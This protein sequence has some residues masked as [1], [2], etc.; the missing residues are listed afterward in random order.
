VPAAKLVWQVTV[1]LWAVELTG[2]LE[3]PPIAPAP[4]LKVIEPD[5]DAL[6]ELEVTVATTV[7]VWLVTGTEGATSV[8]ALVVVTTEVRAEIT[9]MLL[10][11]VL[12]AVSMTSIANPTSAALGA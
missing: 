5:G 6:P 3:Q 7:T 11:P 8:V 1:A 9:G 2:W 12:V 10:P 4:F